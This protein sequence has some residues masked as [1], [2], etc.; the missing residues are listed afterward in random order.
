MGSSNQGTI[1]PTNVVD[2]T[3]QFSGGIDLNVFF[4][5]PTLCSVF[6][7]RISFLGQ[8]I[9]EP[10]L[11]VYK[12]YSTC[13]EVLRSLITSTCQKFEYRSRMFLTYA[14]RKIHSCS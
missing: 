1:S 5:L 4:P 12:N 2:K 9:I 11:T 10:S 8:L 6:L 3:M 13:L 7:E 14:M